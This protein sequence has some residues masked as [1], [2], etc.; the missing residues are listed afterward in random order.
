MKKCSILKQKNIFII[1]LIIY[2]ITCET[3][4]FGLGLPDCCTAIW[5]PEWSTVK[6]GIFWAPLWISPASEVA[7][8]WGG[9][10]LSVI[11]GFM[12][13]KYLLWQKLKD[14]FTQHLSK[15]LAG[16]ALPKSTLSKYECSN[17]ILYFAQFFP[18]QTWMIGIN[19]DHPLTLWGPSV[20]KIQIVL[21]KRDSR[22]SK[23]YK[24]PGPDA[25]RPCYFAKH[26]WKISGVG[27]Q[28]AWV[29]PVL[30]RHL[31]TSEIY[32]IQKNTQINVNFI[33]W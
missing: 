12:G 30:A 19:H 33:I 22:I 6:S 23:K 14:R 16:K 18:S 5:K 4:G 26:F 2:H 32:K 15:D 3:G 21:L 1:E 10:Q 17:M 25:D 27:S 9:D 31:P 13:S 7:R 20:S 24:W 8:D 29:D 28:L 11:G